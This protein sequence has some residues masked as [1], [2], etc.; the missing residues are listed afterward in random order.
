MGTTALRCD[1]SNCD[2]YLEAV[3]PCLTLHAI[4]SSCT[5]PQLTMFT[6][7]CAGGVSDG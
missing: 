3:E 4:D 2:S 7:S 1:N 5:P 6:C